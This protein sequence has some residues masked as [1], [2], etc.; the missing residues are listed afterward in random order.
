MFLHKASLSGRLLISVVKAI[1]V[2]AQNCGCTSCVVAIF[3]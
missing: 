2:S 3:A 1:L